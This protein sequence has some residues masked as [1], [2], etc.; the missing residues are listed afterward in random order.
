MDE[1]TLGYKVTG[2]W[3]TIVEHGERM[4]AAIEIALKSLI[5]DDESISEE[6]LSLL[7]EFGEWRPK[8]EDKSEDGSVNKRTAKSASTET[9]GER[10]TDRLAKAG[11]ELKNKDEKTT[12]QLKN[13]ASHIAKATENT[14]KNTTKEVE[15]FVYQNVMTVI[16]PYYFD[17]QLLSASLWKKDDSTF[18]FE[19]NVNDDQVREVFRDH[20]TDLDMNISRWHTEAEVE[21]DSHAAAESGEINENNGTPTK[22]RITDDEKREDM[23]ESSDSRKNGDF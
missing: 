8:I 9:N 10:S 15:E 21:A 22:D 4:E 1:T 19:V 20:A 11:E 17:N 16:S 18:V 13:T 3:E 2:T 6:Q 7:E 14:V 23:Y 5:E 12:D